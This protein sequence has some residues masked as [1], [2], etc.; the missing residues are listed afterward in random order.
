MVYGDISFRKLRHF[1]FFSVNR[2]R[3]ECHGCTAAIRLIVLPYLPLDLDVQTSAA[4][5]LHARKA[6]RDPNSE[7]WNFVGKNVVR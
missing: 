3:S 6:A 2:A 7:R 4:R 1:F 5:R